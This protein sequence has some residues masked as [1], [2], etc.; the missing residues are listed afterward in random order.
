MSR[1]KGKKQKLPKRFIEGNKFRRVV[2][3][4]PIAIGLIGNH[5]VFI[6]DNL[7]ALDKMH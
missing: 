2:I 4:N 1:Q 7:N 3:P 5:E 6:E